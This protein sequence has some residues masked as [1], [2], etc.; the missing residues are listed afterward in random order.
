MMSVCCHI[1]SFQKTTQSRATSLYTQ[2]SAKE[3][4]CGS[5]GR[6]NTWA[7]VSAAVPHLHRAVPCNKPHFRSVDFV[8]ATLVQSL[9]RHRQCFQGSR[10]PRGRISFSSTRASHICGCSSTHSFQ[11]L[12]SLSWLV[13]RAAV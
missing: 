8:L 2:R 5:N 12:I 4:S 10:C 13:S 11:S 9:F 1:A 3:R 6:F 7:A